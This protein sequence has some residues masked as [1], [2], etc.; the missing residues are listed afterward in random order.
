MDQRQTQITEGAGLE[1]SRIN[2]D[3]LDFLNKWSGPVLMVV[4]LVV[5]AMWGKR[6]L[7]TKHRA[8]VDEAF[9]A[10][11]AAIAGGNPSPE[12]LRQVADDYADVGGVAD[13]AR[14]NTADLYLEAAWLGLRPGA[15]INPDGTPADEADVLDEQ[16]VASYLTSAEDLYRRVLE[17]AEPAGRTLL[18]VKSAWGLAA[19]AASRDDSD[20][21]RT[22]YEQAAMLAEGSGF[23]SLAG[24][25]REKAAGVGDL[26]EPPHLYNANELP[27]VTPDE[28]LDAISTPPTPGPTDAP[29][30]DAEPDEQPE[31]AG[32]QPADEQPAASEEPAPDA[33]PATP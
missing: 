17:S 11:S 31:P 13:M 16:Q 9:S 26:T 27:A 33:E 28:V 22:Y 23:A 5:L 7:D 24:A 8:H 19:V 14:V 15:M 30:G 25:A 3:L 20:R 2:Q 10:Y 6:W 21:A 29:A 12:S 1:E 32:G 4:A 18:A